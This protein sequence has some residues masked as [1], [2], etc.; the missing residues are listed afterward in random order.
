MPFFRLY[1]AFAS[2]YLLSYL[3]RTVNA[4]ISPELTRELLD[5]RNLVVQTFDESAWKRQL[6]RVQMLGAS[7][8]SFGWISC[9]SAG[10]STLLSRQRLQAR[11]HRHGPSRA[12]RCAVSLA[13]LEPRTANP[14]TLT[15]RQCR[16]KLA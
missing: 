14:R 10:V 6:I 11:G 2:G 4:V 15:R 5:H 12:R 9:L 3:F 7:I 13:N 16:V 8:G 1:F